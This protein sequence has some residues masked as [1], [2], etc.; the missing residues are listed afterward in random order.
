MNPKDYINVAWR[1]L[2]PNKCV[3]A[4]SGTNKEFGEWLESLKGVYENEN[5]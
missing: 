4:F 1:E 2:Q 3:M 5:I